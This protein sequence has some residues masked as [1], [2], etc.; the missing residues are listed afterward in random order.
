MTPAE[1]L[2]LTIQNVPTRPELEAYADLRRLADKWLVRNH[3][4]RA[5]HR[6]LSSPPPR[7]LPRF[8]MPESR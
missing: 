6:V 5:Y 7:R 3:Q 4:A 2:M 8:P 1:H